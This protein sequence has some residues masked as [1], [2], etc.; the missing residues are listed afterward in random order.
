M[1]CWLEQCF[2]QKGEVMQ[3]D[4]RLWCVLVCP[5]QRVESLLRADAGD[6]LHTPLCMKTPFSP[7][8]EG[9]G[10]RYWG[11]WPGAIKHTCLGNTRKFTA[12][13]QRDSFS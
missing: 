13:Q 10:Q 2:A 3:Q 5:G 4:Q 1:M 6:G 7:R 8:G 9:R 12:S 11:R